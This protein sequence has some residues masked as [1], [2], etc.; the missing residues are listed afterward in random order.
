MSGLLSRHL[1]DVVS[2]LGAFSHNTTSRFSNL[3]IESFVQLAVS[4]V[5]SLRRGNHRD[6]YFI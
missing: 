2:S 1:L 5:C 3:S 6:I 4:I